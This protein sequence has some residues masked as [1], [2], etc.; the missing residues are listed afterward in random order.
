MCFPS[1]NVHF[2]IPN[3]RRGKKSIVCIVLSNISEYLAKSKKKKINTYNNKKHLR[4]YR[5]KAL[6]ASPSDFTRT[7]AA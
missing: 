1:E 5:I 7:N 3:N 2:H 6:G 4:T